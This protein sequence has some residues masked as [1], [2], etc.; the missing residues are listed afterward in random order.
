MK[1]ASFV[2]QVRKY[3]IPEMCRELAHADG[4]DMQ[5]VLCAVFKL[6]GLAA[7]IPHEFQI[8]SNQLLHI[9]TRIIQDFCLHRRIPSQN[10]DIKA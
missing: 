10:S 4:I 6:Q 5:L 9:T 8:R 1:I 7:S 3:P 2:D